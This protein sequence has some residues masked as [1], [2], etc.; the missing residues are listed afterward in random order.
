MESIELAFKNSE[1]GKSIRTNVSK[2]FHDVKRSSNEEIFSRLM[3]DEEFRKMASEHLLNKVYRT[4]KK[5][6]GKNSTLTKVS[7][8]TKVYGKTNT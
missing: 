7:I 6:E 3:S 5:R 4:K 1:N 2:R 8:D